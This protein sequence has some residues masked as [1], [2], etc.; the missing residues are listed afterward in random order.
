MLIITRHSPSDPIMNKMEYSCAARRLPVGVGVL[1]GA[2]AV[3]LAP[4]TF[5]V[6]CAGEKD[7]ARLFVPDQITWGAAPAS[8]PKGAMM[9]ILEGDPAK[10]VPFVFRLKLPDGYRVMPHWHNKPERLT[11]ISGKLFFGMGAQFD[12]AACKELPAGTYGQWPPGMKHF[13]HVKGETI[14]QLHGTGPWTIEYVNK[15]DDPRIKKK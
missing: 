2:V 4:L 9:A 10:E 1:L 5:S 7:K 15:A 12:A 8:L 11:V 6:S 13:A 3:S 14:L